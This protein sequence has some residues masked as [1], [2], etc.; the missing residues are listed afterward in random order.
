MCLSVHLQSVA[1]ASCRNLVGDA[2]AVDEVEA[3]KAAGGAAL[4]GEARDA[5]DHGA[6]EGGAAE[7]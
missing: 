6:G 5:S 7:R 1:E 4:A 2:D 3:R